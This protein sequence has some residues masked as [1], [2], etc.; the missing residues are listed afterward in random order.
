MTDKAPSADEQRAAQRRRARG[1]FVAGAALVAPHLRRAG[2]ERGFA[3]SRLLTHWA[4]FVGS[5]LAAICRPDR[6]SYARKGLG[7][8]LTLLVSGPHAP[9]VEAGREALRARVNAAYGY[10]A[11]SRIRLVQ[12][13]P[14]VF[15]QPQQPA[16]PPQPGPADRARAH[17]ETA[18]IR[19]PGLRAALEGLAASILARSEPNPS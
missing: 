17:A 5:D 9:L 3:V 16:A 1:G 19:D 7:A 12:V 6:V 14:E 10:N 15:A 11:V 2:E 4:E 8:T 18:G 13:G